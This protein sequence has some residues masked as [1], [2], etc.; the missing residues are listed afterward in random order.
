[1]GTLFL[2]MAEALMAAAATAVTH[3]VPGRWRFRPKG[4]FHIDGRAFDSFTG[5]FWYENA[6]YEMGYA[7]RLPGDWVFVME[8]LTPAARA[9]NPGYGIPPDKWVLVAFHG[10]DHYNFG[11]MKM[12]ESM[13]LHIAFLAAATV[14]GVPILVDALFA[15]GVTSIPDRLAQL[16]A[17]G[18]ANK[19]IPA[20]MNV[21]DLCSPS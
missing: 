16:S 4:V 19:P 1:M 15:P 2:S 13:P 12:P 3:N 14:F 20:T 10:K 11:V 5:E 6:R 21:T 17:W 18:F 8:R 7:L 9:Q